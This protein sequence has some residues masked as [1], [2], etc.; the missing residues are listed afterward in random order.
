MTHALIVDDQL[1]NRYLLR[2]MLQGHGYSVTEASNG[3]EALAEAR[4]APPDVVI[5]DLLM[6]VMDGYAL[7]HEWK[8]DTALNPIPFIVYTATYTEPGDEQAALEFGADAFIIKPAEPESFMARLQQVLTQ[9]Q[10]GLLPE[11]VPPDNPEKGL[12]LY[13][14][15][16]VQKLAKKA[17]QLDQ[18]IAQLTA[19][20]AYNHRLTRLYATLSA[21]NQAIVH[22][23]D[24]D[25]LFQA[26]CRIAVERG[27]FSLAWIGL[28]D[29][30]N[31]EITPVA[32]HGASASWFDEL[33]PFSIH[34]SPR[35]PVE[36]ALGEQRIYLCNELLNAPQHAAIRSSLRHS[37]LHSAASLPLM[38]NGHLIG[39]LTLFAAEA[40]YF[41][42]QITQLAGEIAH[43]IAFAIESRQREQQRQQAE[44]RLL[45]NEE[46]LRL[47][48][49]AVE[50]SANGI[51]ITHIAQPGNP[52]IYVNPAFERITG[53]TKAEVLNRSSSFL[54]GNERDQLGM[55]E[56]RNALRERRE[57]Q[58][59][60]RN[61]RKDGSLFWNDLSIAP[62]RNAQS[63]VTHYIGIINDV[64]ERKQYEEQLERQNNQDTL[65]GLA[66][67]N[68]LHDRTEQA[69]ASASWHGSMVALLFLD[70]DAFKRINES[71]GHGFGDTILRTM[72]NRIV[73]CVAN[74]DTVARLGGDEFAILLR[75]MANMRDISVIAQRILTS[76]AQ[77]L[78]IDGR[79][80]N[81][82]ASM[83]ISLY[84]T[85]GKTHDELLRNADTA[86]YQ[87]KETGRNRFH[88][89]T[90][91]LNAQ[92]IER[93]EL[94]A[95]LRHAA[96]RNQLLL[97]YQPLK[98]LHDDRVADVEALLRWQGE[99]GR[100][101]SPADFIPLAEDT[102]LIVPIGEWVLQAA[103]HQARAWHDMGLEVRVAVNISARQ[104]RDQN[105]ADMIER[106]LTSTRLPPHR[107]KLEIT[108]SAVMEDAGKA[109][110]ILHQLK[111]LG[112]AISV[113]DFGTGYSSLAYL[114][115]FPI[116][117]LKIDR[118]F[119]RDVTDHPDSAAIVRSVIGLARNLRL[120]T[121][122]EG[123]ETEPQRAFLK[124]AGCDLMQGFLFSRPVPAEQIPALL[125]GKNRPVHDPLNLR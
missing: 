50:A 103:C 68:L 67:R 56:V 92:A 21:T 28:L 79:E 86:M 16:L 71:L 34:G 76:I 109:I 118:S 124:E 52:L 77:P 60:L 27:G 24:R 63:E 55:T 112:L 99:D 5:S 26:I 18:R 95:R 42:E 110:D 62:V 81:L 93:L 97:H 25:A 15:A 106:S 46:T 59:L 3:A 9:A 22:T 102:G 120:Q 40:H 4:H 70:L 39:A 121:V 65:T 33:R 58:A 96:N 105:L 1:E 13:N 66:N 7:L 117:Q 115:R 108:E 17:E 91:D 89:Y 11:R 94:E 113:D 73:A 38:P 8:T 30:N 29:A 48:A 90:A 12:R 84:P 35:A 57:T 80:F 116:D 53:Y 6:P 51:I 119:V 88:F 101:I 45:A 78:S 122:A 61:F 14:H 104:F 107:L 114:Q 72:A 23:A 64:T 32:W 87:A 36:F 10:A 41:D 49:R 74:R 111:Q 37:G 44:T 47:N 2:A 43:D 123:V 100:L 31:G 69:I 83:G 98:N 85:D 75:D 54:L 82:S 19:A 20:E 125:T